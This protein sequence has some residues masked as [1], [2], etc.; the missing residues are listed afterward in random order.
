MVIDPQ[1]R[2]VDQ[3]R[4]EQLSRRRSARSDWRR[5]SRSTSFIAKWLARKPKDDIL[6]HYGNWPEPHLKSYTKPFW[7]MY[8]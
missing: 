6:T 7:G 4:T 5:P 2:L 8:D 3:A 1:T